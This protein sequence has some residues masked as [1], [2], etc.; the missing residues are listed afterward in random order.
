MAYLCIMAWRSRSA[1]PDEVPALD[2][3]IVGCQW[4]RVDRVGIR[5]EDLE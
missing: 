2:E 1:A 3:A 5:L 4:V